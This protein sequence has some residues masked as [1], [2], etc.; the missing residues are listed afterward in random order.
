[1]NESI[2]SAH[3]IRRAFVDFFRKKDH[4]EVPGSALVPR[5]DPTLLF[6]SAGMVQFKD[7][8][9][10]PENLPYTRAVSVQKCLRA[11][12]LDLVGKT[13]RHHTFF[14]M[15]GNFSFG[16]YFKEEAIQWAWEFFIDWLCL[17]EDKLYVSVFEDDQEA[18]GIWSGNIGID[19]KRIYRLGREDNFWGPV[20]KTGICGPCSEIYFDAGPERGCGRDGCAPGCDCDRYLEI[21]NL[22]FPQYFLE[23]SGKYRKLR[24]PGIDTGLG[25]ERLAFIMQD[26]EDNFHTDLFEPIIKGLRDQ[27]P[28]DID[29][30]DQMSI[31]M[32][33]DHL[34][35]LTFTIA[36]GV[37]PSNEGRGYLLRRLLRR[38]LTRFHSL[39]LDKPFLHKLVDGV[40]D[41]MKVDYPELEEK[42]GNVAM[43]IRSEE[44][45]FF[46]TLIEGEK[47]FD[48]MAREIKEKG[49]N[50]VDGEKV[51]LLYDTFGVPPE[52]SE[53][54]AEKYEL[55]IDHKGYQKAM[56]QQ[57][58]SARTDSA[59]GGGKEEIVSMKKISSGESSVFIGY[60]N[61]GCN[62]AVRRYRIVG[63]TESNKPENSGKE[64]FDLELVLD[65]TPFYPTSG[66]QVADVGHITVGDR[67]FR[68]KDVFKRGGEIVHVIE[69]PEEVSAISDVIEKEKVVKAEI[70]SRRR[71]S[72]ARNHTATHLLHAALR[73]V[74]GEHI[75]QAGSLVDDRRLRF[76]FN[77]FQPLSIETIGLVEDC[78]NE[79]VRDCIPVE[80][81]VMGMKEALDSG[82]TALFDEKYGEE[83]RVVK[84]GDVSAELCGGVH[85]YNTGQ[86]GLFVVISEGSAAAGTRRIEAVTGEAAVEYL[87]RL[88]MGREEL[89]NILKVSGSE[90]KERV[91][92]LLHEVE[93]LKKYIRKLESNEVGSELDSLIKSAEKYDGLILVRGRLSVRTISAM[94]NQ[95]DIFRSKVPSGIAV[96]SAV[97]DEKL[98]F[99]IA[100]TDDLIEEKGITATSIVDMLSHV[101][102]IEGGGK[103]HLAQMGTKDIE[104][105]R[106]IFKALPG[107]IKELNG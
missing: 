91:V 20:G 54:L 43:I 73:K 39:G 86:L 4:T 40:V 96:L 46:K 107:I 33:A 66:G 101:T 85:V 10:T 11:G 16:D 34:R 35:A 92:S 76:D 9:L 41:V 70:N 51:F 25:L 8:Y 72:T 21:W 31:N 60:D 30:I 44:D 90:V 84:I 64:N 48:E 87:R 19:E 89:G 14:E 62:S 81:N 59:F 83:V 82:A 58:K 49:E 38:S 24:D 98:Q 93:D 32:V 103:R 100:A 50:V 13:L 12:D 94:R 105:E 80:V 55:R 95:A 28:D 88:K 61:T 15:L 36:E 26:V 53:S 7:Y 17:P 74:V 63:G 5:N 106:K 42:R 75:T 1:M 67:D 52:L 68:V 3:E 6:T 56:E 97:V 69:V 78:V 2:R 29:E 37:Y 57:R 99:V 22:V 47:R 27:L 71:H 18:F 45:N 23:E 79:W 102:G 77:H 65:K 104:S